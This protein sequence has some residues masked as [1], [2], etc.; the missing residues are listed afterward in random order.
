MVTEINVNKST[1][2]KE[3]IESINGL[4]KTEILNMVKMHNNH[5]NNINNQNINQ[6]QKNQKKKNKNIPNQNKEQIDSSVIVNKKT[7]KINKKN[8]NQSKFIDVY[9]N[10]IQYLDVSNTD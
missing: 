10:N 6:N 3:L 9:S 7:Y 4:K 8:L 1:T 5:A 2:K